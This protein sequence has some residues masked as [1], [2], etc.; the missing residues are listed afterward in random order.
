MEGVKGQTQTPSGLCGNNAPRITPPIAYYF[1]KQQLLAIGNERPGWDSPLP[2][3]G[4]ADRS[5]AFFCPQCGEVWGRI[6]LPGARWTFHCSGCPA[7]PIWPQ[8]VGGSFISPC[9]TNLS[10]L[11]EAVLQRELAIR[12]EKYS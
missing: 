5:Q 2:H 6:F 7:H 12:L 8:D 4:R 3:D 1:L 9:Q 11:P 10:G